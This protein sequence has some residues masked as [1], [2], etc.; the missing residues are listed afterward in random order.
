MTFMGSWSHQPDRLKSV[1][2]A[3]V[4]RL[5]D[6]QRV[7]PNFTLFIFFFFFRDKEL[8]NYTRARAKI[9]TGL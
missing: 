6:I 5:Q 1:L 7:V 8:A 2:V 3:P 4:T 9:A